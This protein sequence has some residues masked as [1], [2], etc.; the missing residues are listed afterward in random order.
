ML[1]K[2]LIVDDE[3]IAR[4]VLREELETIRGV[5]VIAEAESGPSA[6]DQIARHS[7]DLV[8]LDLQMPRM[9]GL[10]V[11]RCLRHSA[12]I[13][14][15]V[16]VTAHD[17][18]ALDA[19]DAG[20]IDYLLKPVRTQRLVQAVER[21]KHIG[22]RQRV[23]NLAHLQEIAESA[24]GAHAVS[25][26]EVR[27]VGKLGSEFYLLKAEEILAFQANGEIV[28]ILTP[29]RTFL[30]TQTLQEI[31]RR[32]SGFG[33][34]RIHRNALVNLDHIRKI[35]ALSSQRWLVTLSNHQELV[36]S[37]RLGRSIRSL[38]KA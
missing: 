31:D 18:H 21:A 37:K 28:S 36:V 13:P 15:F 12:H 1:L 17:Q 11:V 6:L 3:P 27:V 2:T 29:K 10:D 19:F 8:L 34:R 14:I 5:Q 26:K 33:F 20:A 35:S 9:G 22:T 25:S 16:I 24:A 30:A 4:Q 23:E 7:P 32:L 38:L